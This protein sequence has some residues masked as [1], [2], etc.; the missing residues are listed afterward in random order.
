[1]VVFDF[2]GD[3]NAVVLRF[4][5]FMHVGIAITGIVLAIIF[6]KVRWSQ[7]EFG[8]ARAIQTLPALS[9]AGP[10]VSPS[11]VSPS[12]AAATIES[13]TVDEIVYLPIIS[14]YYNAQL[15]TRIGFGATTSP[16]TRYPEVRRLNAGWYVDWGVNKK[17]I[18]PAGMDYVQMVRSPKYCHHQWLASM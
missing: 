14:K 16:I 18:R 11:T 9:L 10:S 5:R 1:M 7:P 8:A 2:E 3:G 6:L 15:S 13:S 17:P 4:R 12:T